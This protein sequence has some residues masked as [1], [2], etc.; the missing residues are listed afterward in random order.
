MFMRYTEYSSFRDACIK[1]Y[2]MLKKDNFVGFY[3]VV[4]IG[5]MWVFFGGNPDETYYGVRTVSVE[6]TTGKCEWFM[7]QYE[8]N[9]DKIENGMKVEFPHR[10]SYKSNHIPPSGIH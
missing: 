10:F 2:A 4:D 1:A 6:K 7:A 5:D 3:L 9:N 8:E